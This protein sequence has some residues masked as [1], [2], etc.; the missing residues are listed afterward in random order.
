LALRIGSRYLRELVDYW[1]KRY[2]W[3]VAEV[4][5]HR[6]AQFKVQVED[7]DIRFVHVRGSGQKPFPLI[8]THGWPG[9]FC[10]RCSRE[11][12]TTDRSRC[13]CP[14]LLP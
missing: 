13:R 10:E 14:Q 9:S 12:G 2:D 3:R 1:L 7:A 11:G 5:L 6:Y 4:Q 8:L